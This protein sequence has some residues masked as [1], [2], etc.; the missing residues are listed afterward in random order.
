MANETLN[1]SLSQLFSGILPP[2]TLSG[3]GFLISLGKVV[4]ITFLIYLVF[5]IIQS[6]VRI[7]QALRLK[8]LDLNVAE[9]NKKLD[10]LLSKKQKKPQP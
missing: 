7:K 5:L 10:V 3:L 1:I 8:S 4:G 6:F 9:I 2:E